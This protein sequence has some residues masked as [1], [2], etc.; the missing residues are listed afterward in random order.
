MENQEPINPIII[1]G[2]ELPFL[3]ICRINLMVYKDNS[4]YYS[5]SKNST[6]KI[7]DVGFLNKK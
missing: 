3:P 5:I 4:I 2:N 6:C 7:I 1:F